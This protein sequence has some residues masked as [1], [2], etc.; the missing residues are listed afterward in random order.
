LS[1]ITPNAD[2]FFEFIYI[3]I[4]TATQKDAQGENGELRWSTNTALPLLTAMRSETDYTVASWPAATGKNSLRDL[5]DKS[6]GNFHISPFEVYRQIVLDDKYEVVQPTDYEDALDEALVRVNFNLIHHTVYDKK[7]Q[8][9]FNSCVARIVDVVICKPKAPVST[10]SGSKRKQGPARD[11]PW[12]AHGNVARLKQFIS[13][14]L[15]QNCSA[16]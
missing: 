10:I 15:L 13:S 8:V 1:F 7:T 9:N 14:R 2:S 11:S 5:L 6:S 12:V 16:K 4:S 3:K